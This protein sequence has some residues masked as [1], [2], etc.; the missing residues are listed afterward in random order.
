MPAHLMNRAAV[1]ATAQIT[2]AFSLTSLLT[3]IRSVSP[4]TPSTRCMRQPG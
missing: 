2:V 3:F 4:L 1:Q